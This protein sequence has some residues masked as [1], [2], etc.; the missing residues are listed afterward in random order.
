MLVNKWKCLLSPYT[1]T[2]SI[3][4]TIQDSHVLCEYLESSTMLKPVDFLYHFFFEILDMKT[5]CFHESDTFSTSNSCRPWKVC[6]A[7]W[8]HSLSRFIASV[9]LPIYSIN[10]WVFDFLPRF[11]LTELY[12]EIS[13]KRVIGGILQT[14]SKDGVPTHAST[15]IIQ[16]YF[17]ISK[18]KH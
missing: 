13:N 4:S 9:R 18:G 3:T 2:I 17:P 10:F 12:S 1:S 11:T 8:R 15:M 6:P 5:N 7:L 14:E 16:L